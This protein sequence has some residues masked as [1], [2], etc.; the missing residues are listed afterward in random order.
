MRG[1]TSPGTVRRGAR[2]SR[3]LPWIGAGVLAAVVGVTLLAADGAPPSRLSGVGMV[4]DLPAP[5]SPLIR[6]E[7][8]AAAPRPDS[9]RSANPD[10]AAA[11]VEEQRIA[12]LRETRQRL[13]SEIALLQEEAERRL[14]ELPG[15][16]VMPD[17]P[18]PPGARFASVPL[19]PPATAAPP[20]ASAPAPA[21]AAAPPGDPALRGLRVFVH[22]RTNS[23]QGAAA[24]DDVA[25]RLRDTGVDLQ[26][27]RSAAFVPSTPVVRYFHDEDQAAAARIAGRLGRGW[28]IQDFRAYQPQPAPQ[29]IEVWIPGS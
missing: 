14:R 13:E 23:S 29:T 3:R 2:S 21:V 26:A 17:S 18:Q 12:Q 7:S 4:P 28:A 16:K 27:P 10:G 5:Q 9:A 1:R 22:H 25:D 8:R 19:P 24:A 20:P 6:Q 15:R 11:Q